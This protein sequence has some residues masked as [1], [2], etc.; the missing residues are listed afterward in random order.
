MAD[1][2]LGLPKEVFRRI[3]YVEF[4]GGCLSSGKSAVNRNI[5]QNS[6]SVASPKKRLA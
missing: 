6:S 2:G 5:C 1:G 3:T 4:L